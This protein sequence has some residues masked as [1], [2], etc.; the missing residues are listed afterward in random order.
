MRNSTETVLKS[1]LFAEHGERPRAVEG[2]CIQRATRQAGLLLLRGVEYGKLRFT[3]PAD[4]WLELKG[5]SA[6]GD[7]LRSRGDLR[8]HRCG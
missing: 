2:C 4:E 5:G 1:R 7:K 3:M 6:R 8:G